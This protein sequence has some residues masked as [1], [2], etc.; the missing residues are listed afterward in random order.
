M[1]NAIFSKNGILNASND[2]LENNYSVKLFELSCLKGDFISAYAEYEYNLCSLL[3]AMK[4]NN[5]FKDLQ[6]PSTT[7][8][9]SSKLLEL[10]STNQEVSSILGQINSRVKKIIKFERL[11]NFIAHGIVEIFIRAK[12][13][14]EVY[15]ISFF[16]SN[17][18]KDK[19][20]VEFYEVEE[21]REYIKE[22]NELL[23]HFKSHSAILIKKFKEYY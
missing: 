19:P 15:A 9:K 14:K 4:N 13:K 8:Q 10:K 17:S 3:L 23:K 20:D 6:I 12:D 22:L 21:I 2:N 5:E 1:N 18:H 7:S 11:R 16:S